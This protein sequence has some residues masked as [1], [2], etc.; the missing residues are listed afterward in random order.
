MVEF[1]LKFA[2]SVTDAIALVYTH[3][4]SEVTQLLKAIQAGDG[5]AAADLLPLVYDEL[6]KLAAARMANEP[7][8]RPSEVV[9]IGLQIAEGLAAAHATDQ[10]HLDIKPANILLEG[11]GQRVKIT[12]FGLARAVDDASNSQSMVAGTPVYMAP[13][14]ARGEALNPRADLFSFGSVLYLMAAGRRRSGPP[15][16]W[17]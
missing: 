16:R 11:G 6:R 4:T 2:P 10:I 13:E 17:Q 9:R 12:D 8:A 7:P 14:Q 15:V 3:E 1:R 5:K